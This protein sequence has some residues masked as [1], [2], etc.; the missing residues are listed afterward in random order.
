MG[1]Y[2]NK[3]NAGKPSAARQTPEDSKNPVPGNSQ[4]EKIVHWLSQVKFRPRLFGVDQA[5]VWKKLEEL[6]SLYDK[7]L[8]AERARYDVLLQMNSRKADAQ[9]APEEK[10]EDELL[11]D[12]AGLFPEDAWE[13]GDNGR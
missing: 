6:N 4:L 12:M 2:A 3:G 1:K 9:E 8:V 10:P 13:D 5:D 7:A 11:E